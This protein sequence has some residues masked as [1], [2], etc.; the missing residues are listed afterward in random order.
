MRPRRPS[1][2]IVPVHDGA[3]R[4]RCPW[5]RSGRATCRDQL[6]ADRR[7]RCEHRRDGRGRG[8]VRGPGHPTRRPPSGPPTP[9][10]AA[11]R[12]PRGEVLVFVDADVCVH[13]DALLTAFGRPSRRT[14]RGRRLRRYDTD[15]PAP[16]LVSQYRNLLHH[17]VHW[18]HAGD[19][20]TFWAGLGAVRRGEFLAVGRIRRTPLPA[21]ADRGHRARLPPARAGAA[22]CWTRDPGAR[23]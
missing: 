18:R 6:G 5:P 7:G 1:S 14:R 22:S 8:P 15:P 9:A 3:A 20:D 17:Y 4:C 16:G 21:P 2:V 23:T 19:A 10:T 12:S 13:P 11:A